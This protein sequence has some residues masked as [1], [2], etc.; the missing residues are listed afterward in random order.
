MV[1]DDWRER[2]PILIREGSCYRLLRQF[3]ANAVLPGGKRTPQ[4]PK[5]EA[6]LVR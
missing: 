4:R 1:S 3:G 6:S 5:Y 2:F